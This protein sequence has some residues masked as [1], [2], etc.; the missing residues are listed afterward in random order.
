MLRSSVYKAQPVRH[1]CQQSKVLQQA[2]FSCAKAIGWLPAVLIRIC[3][4][5][6][7]PAI[8][9]TPSGAHQ[10]IISSVSIPL[11]PGMPMGI[12][13]MGPDGAGPNMT[14]P[15]P[16]PAANRPAG[17]TSATAGSRAA[18]GGAAPPPG[19]GAGQGAGRGQ[20]MGLNQALSHAL[21]SAMVQAGGQAM[22]PGSGQ[23]IFSLCVCN[24]C[25]ASVLL[26]CTSH[27]C[28]VPLKASW[29]LPANL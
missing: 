9:H 4:A 22:R 14:G 7:A 18:G 10:Q 29:L 21:Q 19:A 5:G 26:A 13:P 11:F 24:S 20:G 17:P 12:A 23:T 28:S 2:P 8:G 3:V 15:I 16:G 25:I 27:R 6:S 1:C